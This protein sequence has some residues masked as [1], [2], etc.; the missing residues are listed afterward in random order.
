MF[1]AAL[2][3]FLSENNSF[4]LSLT[5][6]LFLWYSFSPI[7]TTIKLSQVLLQHLKQFLKT[8]F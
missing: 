8:V 1:L 7:L 6:V 4:F 3:S 5:L 2:Y